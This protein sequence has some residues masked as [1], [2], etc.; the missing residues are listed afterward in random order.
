VIDVLHRCRV[1]AGCSIV[2]THMLGEVMAIAQALPN[3]RI[4]LQ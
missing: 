4:A 1:A 3:D 2:G